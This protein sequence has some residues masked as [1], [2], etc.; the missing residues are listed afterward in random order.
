MAAAMYWK[1]RMREDVAS[2]EEL[3]HQT[4]SGQFHESNQC[5]VCSGAWT[6]VNFPNAAT[7]GRTLVTHV[8]LTSRSRL[9]YEA[10]QA[11]RHVV[12]AVEKCDGAQA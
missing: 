3:M 6:F 10:P 11:A 12:S 5:V 7:R 4:E 1:T 8:S 2:S 9:F